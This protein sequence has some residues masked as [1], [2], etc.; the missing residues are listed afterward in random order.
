MSLQGDVRAVLKTVYKDGVPTLL[1]RLDPVFKDVEKMVYRGKELRY[2]NVYGR[3][4]G[5]AS[6]KR[7]AANIATSQGTK[8]AEWVVPLDQNQLFGVAVITQKQILASKDKA[9]AY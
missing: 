3:A 7:I 6:N 5:V 4:P 9:G 2:L 1:G 8:N